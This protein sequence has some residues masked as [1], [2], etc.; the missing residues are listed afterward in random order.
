MFNIREQRREAERDRARERAIEIESERERAREGSRA[1]EKARGT[2]A[3][4]AQGPSRTCNKSKEEG[5]FA[6]A[7][8]VIVRR[9]F[10]ERRAGMALPQPLFVWHPH[11]RSS[12]RVQGSGCRV[13]GSGFRA[14]GSGFRVQGAGCRVQV[15]LDWCA[16][17]GL[18]CFNQQA[19]HCL[20]LTRTRAYTCEAYRCRTK[21]GTTQRF[22]EVLPESQD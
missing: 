20:L 15:L 10:L 3:L 4:K 2:F 6:R 9:V 12:G 21:R 19:C 11:L 5:T 8:P 17:P 18:A 22:E 1:R 13:Q 14:Q 7:H 16:L